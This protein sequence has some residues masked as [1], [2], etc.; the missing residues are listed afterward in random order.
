[1][2]KFRIFFLIATLFSM[3]LSAITVNGFTTIY[4]IDAKTRGTEIVSMITTFMTNQKSNPLSEVMIQTTNLNFKGFPSGPTNVIN[5]GLIPFVQSITAATNSTLLMVTFGVNK[6][7]TPSYTVVVPIEEIVEVILSTN[8]NNIATNGLPIQGQAYSTT[9]P[10]G[11][12]PLLSINAG[13][14]ATDIVFV[15]NN[16]ASKATSAQQNFRVA[17]Q[18]A[19]SATSPRAFYPPLQFNGV[20][21]FL[22]SNAVVVNNEFVQFTYQQTTATV[23]TFTLPAE[24]VDQIYLYP[25]NASPNQ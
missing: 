17:V 2:S 9:Y 20:F 21:P 10:N 12:I 5:Q 16:L 6:N 7:G 13:Q 3:T 23:G 18:T 11:I 14:R 24:Q 1:M 19:V 25:P 8:T 22:Q 15:I 4:P